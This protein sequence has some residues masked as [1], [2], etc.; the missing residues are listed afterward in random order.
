MASQSA[1]RWDGQELTTGIEGVLRRALRAVANQLVEIIYAIL[2]TRTPYSKHADEG[3]AFTTHLDRESEHPPRKP[4]G[5]HS[6]W[7]GLRQKLR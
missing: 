2:Q 6:T 7:P 1:I 3:G 4:H 5:Q